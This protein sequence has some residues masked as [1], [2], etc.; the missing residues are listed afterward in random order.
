MEKNQ[1]G[2]VCRLRWTIT[3]AN[4]QDIETSPTIQFKLL[5]YLDCKYSLNLPLCIRVA[6]EERGSANFLEGNAL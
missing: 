4:F 1:V 5:N 3:L 2:T 6:V